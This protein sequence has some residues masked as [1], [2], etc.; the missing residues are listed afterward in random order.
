MTD[1]MLPQIQIDVLGKFQVIRGETHVTE[2]EWRAAKKPQ[3]LLKVLITRG[4]ENVLVDL[5]I[6][7]LW[8]N[9]SLD[10][11]KQNF[12]V[13]LHRL[14]KI[15]GHPAGASY[16]SFDGNA[17]SLNRNLV[18][19]D[20]DEF[21]SLCKRAR[22]TEEAG[23]IKGSL[24]FGNAAVELYKGDYLEDDLYTP[25]TMLKRQEIRALYIDV[26][27]RTA[28]LYERQGNSR[29][30]IDVFK[31]LT[32]ADPLLEEAYRKLMLLYSNIG[33]R[34]E[35]IRVYNECR[36]ALS[37]ELDVDPDELTT[38]IYRRVVESGPPDK[39][40]RL[41]FDRL[42]SYTP[43]YLAEKILAHRISIEGERKTVT[44]MFAEVDKSA[45]AFEKLDPEAVH[46]I[47]DGCFRI[48]LDEVHRF[49]GTVNQ[50][51]GNE[52]MALFGAPLA[53]EDHAQRACHAALAIQNAVALYTESLRNR[54]GIDF[55][56][57]IGLNSGPVV[58]GAIG[59]DLRMDYTAQG[60][61]V[62]L[63]AAAKDIA[64]PGAILV[65][66]NLY[67][68]ARDFFV[69]EPV[70]GV[71]FKEK[72]LAEAH[73]LIKSTGLETKFA[74]SIARGLILFCVQGHTNDPRK[75]CHAC[76]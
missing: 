37:S 6:D 38:S 23:D 57:C 34:T 15:L 56:M 68:L 21:L 16:I 5:L 51:L 17:A 42:H 65:S 26:L 14:R 4:A 39:E 67:K 36:Q 53:H 28:S 72:G 71:K 9:T 63:A 73:R 40:K 50:F 58:V 27:R 49:E 59:N 48:M 31:L 64:E 2:K 47:M 75:P 60:D 22:R 25:W 70:G 7:D 62:D 61:T 74:A 18:R 44:V 43:K 54:Y 20:I 52:V 12:R 45:A 55:K 13:V 10:E 1:E 29:K 41:D 3:M 8:P 33:M 69:F 76:H 11:G 66:K 46:E 30:A 35:A 19:L 24:D 32:R